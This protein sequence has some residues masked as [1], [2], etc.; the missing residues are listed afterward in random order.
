MLRVRV[1]P[2]LLLDN[3]RLVKTINFKKP[4][5]IG[6][7]INAVKIFNEKEMDE[8]VILDISATKE[9]KKPNIKHI[10]EIASEAFMPLAY[11]GGIKTL[12]EVKSLFGVGIEKIILNS[13]AHTNTQ[14]IGAAANLFGSQSIVASIDVKKNIFGKK[15]VFTEAGKFNTK[16]SAVDYAK[17]MEEAGAGEI[18][19]TSI[20]RE[21]TFTGF[22]IDLIKEV[23]N[24]VRIPVIA[25]GGAASVNDFAKAVVEGKASAVA[26]GSM[27]VYQGELKG[28]LINF[29]SQEE[30][31]EKLYSIS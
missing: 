22:D 27:F 8:I 13:T 7:P 28:I 16:Y 25:S 3:G 10:E 21:G 20:D 11:G 15:L 17:R 4:N 6:D 1:I 31:K 19:V 5:Y 12:D 18:V 26:A 9:K 24:A 2:T 14:L 29:P 23:S 30:L